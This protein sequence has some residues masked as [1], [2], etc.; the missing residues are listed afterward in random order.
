MKVGIYLT[1]DG[2]CKEAMSFYKGV[3][4]G[5]FEWQQTWGESPMKDDSPEEFKDLI[6]HCSLPLNKTINLMGCDRHPVLH[7][8]QQHVV[9]NNTE[10]CLSP[11]TKTEANR[12][13]AA[14]SSEGGTVS[15]PLQDMPWGSYAGNC[16]D[17]YGIQWMFDIAA[18]PCGDDK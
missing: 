7:T 1:F 9:G 12:L 11:D 3:F 10:I 4:G 16:A 15:I 5:E 6:V 2:N 14:L 8:N 17:K 18:H 13:F